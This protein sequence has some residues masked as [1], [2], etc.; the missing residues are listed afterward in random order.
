MLG[1]LDRRSSGFKTRRLLLANPAV[2]VGQQVAFPTNA[3]SRGSCFPTGSM[4]QGLAYQG[5]CRLTAHARRTGPKDET[6]IEIAINTHPYISSRECSDQISCRFIL[7][8]YQKAVNHSKSLT[9]SNMI[10]IG[11]VMLCFVPVAYLSLSTIVFCISLCCSDYKYRLYLLPLFLAFSI[12]SFSTSKHFWFIPSLV[13]LWS[14]AL[15]LYILH[16]VSLLHLERW[17]A[18]PSLT[19][20]SNPKRLSSKQQWNHA[21]L[22]MYKLWGNPRLL[23]TISVHDDGASSQVRCQSYPTFFF[24]RL[25]KL[26]IYYYVHFKVMPLLFSVTIVEFLPADVSPVQQTMF[27]RIGEVTAR[28]VLIRGHTAVSWIWE[29]VVY[30]DGTNAILA[31]FFVLLGLDCP[32]EWP[33]LFGSPA[34]VTNLR[35]FWARFWH[36][37]AVRPYTNYGKVAARSLGLDP[38]SVPFKATVAFVTFALSGATHSAVSWHLGRR[39]WHLDICWFL[40]NFAACFV[41]RVFL[42]SIRELARTIG[43]SRELKLIER[44]WFGRLIGFTWVFGFF[45]WSVPKWRYPRIY[46]EASQIATLRSLLSKLSIVRS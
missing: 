4:G 29:S 19:P 23:S 31:C 18:P 46:T 15:S 3:G 41:E 12:L 13:S 27:R 1:K 35:N 38:K 2:A 20:P 40:L 42:S 22:A 37:L 34:L 32:S 9:H 5:R 14:Q 36:R 28:E 43:W 7:Y 26:P 25:V 45:F 8:F 39:D 11:S 21:L 16:V 10:S 6:C 17:P 30:L 33:A 24:L 44:S